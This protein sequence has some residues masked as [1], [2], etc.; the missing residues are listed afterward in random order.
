MSLLSFSSACFGFTD[1]QNCAID[2][3]LAAAKNA[4]ICGAPD[5]ADPVSETVVPTVVDVVV[6]VGA[7]VEVVVD[8]GEVVEVVVDPDSWFK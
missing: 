2:S 5:V 6:D 4:R 1:A 3:L 7:V 8:V